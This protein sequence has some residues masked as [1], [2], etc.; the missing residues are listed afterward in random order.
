QR[1]DVMITGHVAEGPV[2]NF[3]QSVGAFVQIRKFTSDGELTV[4]DASWATVRHM[5]RGAWTAS[6]ES[7]AVHQATTRVDEGIGKHIATQDESH[8]RNRG[9]GNRLRDATFET[10]RKRLNHNPHEVRNLATDDTRLGYK[11]SLGPRRNPLNI[12]E[13]GWDISVAR[14]RRLGG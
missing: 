4:Y 11:D 9:P 8:R 3:G 13:L 14:Y 5:K 1:N 10:V 7:F 12:E 6:L 2:N